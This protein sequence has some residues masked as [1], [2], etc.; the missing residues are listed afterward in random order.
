VSKLYENASLALVTKNA[1]D[2]IL[3]TLLLRLAGRLKYL[4]RF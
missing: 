1:I 3:E 4:T 2:G